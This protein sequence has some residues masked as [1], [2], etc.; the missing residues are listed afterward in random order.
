MPPLPNRKNNNTHRPTIEI[1]SSKI[2]IP[3]RYNSVERVLRETKREFSSEAQGRPENA[4]EN[5]VDYPRTNLLVRRP[6]SA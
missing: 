1:L 2:N 4:A 3:A 5:S 6:S